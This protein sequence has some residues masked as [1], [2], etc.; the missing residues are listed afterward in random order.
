LQP[1]G[2]ARAGLRLR[3]GRPVPEREKADF[4]HATNLLISGGN[5]QAVCD[6]FD[7]LYHPVDDEI[8]G[9]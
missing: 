3:R 4:L 1:G 5:E 7:K 6:R 9:I 8:A 2:G